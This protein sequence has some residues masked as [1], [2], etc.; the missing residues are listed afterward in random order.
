MFLIELG[1]RPFEP[2]V[3]AA[4]SATL[5][6]GVVAFMNIATVEEKAKV[7]SDSD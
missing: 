4:V 2:Y 7:V 5:L 1:P 6:V 3:W